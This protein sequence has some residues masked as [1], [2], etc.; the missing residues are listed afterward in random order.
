MT[1]DLAFG[2]ICPMRETNE[3]LL[4]NNAL[5]E[6]VKELRE[7]RGWIAAQMA[8][9]LGV[10]ADRYRKYESRSPLPA[11]L[12]ERFC[13]VVDCDLDYLL[14]GKSRPTA[15]PRTPENERKLQA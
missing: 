15:A 11:Y 7:Q 14:T 6:R 9:A 12:M 5:C 1:S 3:E 13:L 10:P 2:T 4:F 8:T